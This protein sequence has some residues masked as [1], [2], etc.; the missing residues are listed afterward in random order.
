MGN[1]GLPPWQPSGR[2]NQHRPQPRPPQ[3]QASAWIRRNP[4]KSAVGGVIGVFF[5]LAAIGAVLPAPKTTPTASGVTVTASPSASLVAP[6]SPTLAP[7]RTATA[8]VVPPKS[9]PTPA[10]TQHHTTAVQSQLAQAQH[11]QQPAPS[12]SP[13]PPPA[14]A[15]APRAQSGPNVVHP[16]AFC[17]P[18]G[19]TGVT[20]RGTPMVCGT[21]AAS[22]D[23]ARWHAV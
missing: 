7:I 21:T 2:R 4:W 1:Q 22:P 18:E 20:D 14:P 15:S 19:A 3:R 17:A 10:A 8:P 9:A 23:R 13:V 16:G 11:A 5:L 6:A 12:H